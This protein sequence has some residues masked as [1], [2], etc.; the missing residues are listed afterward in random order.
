MFFQK[1]NYTLLWTS[2]KLTIFVTS[3]PDLSLQVTYVK[4]THLNFKL[5]NIIN[6]R[7]NISL[8]FDSHLL[9]SSYS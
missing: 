8:M 7:I 6:L 1:L 9:E 5:D 4:L 2:K 3:A